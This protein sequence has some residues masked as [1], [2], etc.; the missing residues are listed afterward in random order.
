[1]IDSCPQGE[2]AGCDMYLS[3]PQRR[4][5]SVGEVDRRGEIEER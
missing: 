1:V 5:F 4:E 3:R 2:S